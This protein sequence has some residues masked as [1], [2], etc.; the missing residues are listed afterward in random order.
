MSN[1]TFGFLKLIT[2]ILL[3]GA[4]FF[5]GVSWKNQDARTEDDTT[6]KSQIVDASSGQ[7][8]AKLLNNSGASVTFNPQE[9]ATINLFESAA[10]SVAFITTSIVRKDYW[11]RDVTEIP[12][13]SGSA[14][15]W[16]KN[17][18]IITNYHVIQGADRALVTLADQSNWQAKL[19]GA[20]PEKDLAVLKIDAPANKLIPIPVGNSD[21]LKV[22]QSVYAIGNPFGFDQTLTTGIISA[23]GREI[24]SIG[25]V[26]IRDV[27]QTD[28]AINP[29]N[30]G[31]PLLD[32]SGKLIGVNTAIFSPSGSYAG[33]GFSIPVDIVKWVVPDLINFGKINR[34]TLGI[35]LAS[36]N[37]TTRL[38]LDGVLILE[39]IRGSAAE[40]AG[41]QPTRR[42]RYGSIQLGDVLVGIDDNEIK[43]RGDLILTLEKYKPGDEIQV[44][45]MR[46][47]KEKQFPLVLD[48]AR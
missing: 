42:D 11:S 32:S 43:S 46:D 31:G 10:P 23:L 16:N 7:P 41:L 3:I 8:T 37:V 15:V 25:K 12:R 28:A 18:H 2:W 29:G 34:P 6:K 19:I 35:E 45:V 27:I 4:G 30:S 1:Q 24:E 14:F 13:G 33:I 5:A 20:A 40:R 39:V 36:A 22:G 21:R 47:Y 38:G 26:P 48:M 9:Q 44:K 17:G